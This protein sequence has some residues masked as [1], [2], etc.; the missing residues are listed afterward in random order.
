[1]A[2]RF[3][4]LPAP[5]EF[6]STNFP[7]LTISNTTERRLV[8]AFDTTT[9][10]TCSWTVVAPQGWTSGF[11]AVLS[12]SMASATT[13][14]IAFEVG[15]EAITTGDATDLDAGT[16]Y[17]TTNTATDSGVPGTAGYMEQISLTLTNHDSS[18]AADLLRI[19]F[20]RAP[21]NGTDTATGD[22]LLHALEIRDAA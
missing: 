9:Q 20:R 3:V 4:L 12:Y 16:S 18:A 11:T 5:A 8:L 2:T 14:G 7:Q 21:A 22:L 19:Y 1:V 10:E 13:G 6:P 15:I 17:D